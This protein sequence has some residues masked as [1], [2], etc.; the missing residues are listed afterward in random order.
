M[1]VL[2][3]VDNLEEFTSQCTSLGDMFDGRTVDTMYLKL[4]VG[5]AY[6]MRLNS[7]LRST[8]DVCNRLRAELITKVPLKVL[9]DIAAKKSQSRTTFVAQFLG[10]TVTFAFN[11][12]NEFAPQCNTIITALGAQSGDRI[13]MSKEGGWEP[14]NAGYARTPAD[15]CTQIGTFAKM[16]FIPSDDQIEVMGLNRKF[17]VETV[18]SGLPFVFK[19][20]SPEQLYGQCLN[21]TSHLQGIYFVQHRTNG[22]MMRKIELEGRGMPSATACKLLTQD[23]KFF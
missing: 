9:A 6:M 23:V 19:V 13:Y 1:E 5:Q 2:F 20:N 16:G 14:V 17:T 3:G 10:N 11:S 4:N 22:G 8:Q 15:I 7:Y 18:F 21:L 12:E